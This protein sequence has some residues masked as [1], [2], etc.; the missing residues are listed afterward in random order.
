MSRITKA[1]LI[2]KT[3]LGRDLFEYGVHFID[4]D[5]V[6]VALGE[7]GQDV[8]LTSTDDLEEGS[9]HLYYTDARVQA[10]IDNA[11]LSSTD[12]LPE[13]ST[14]KYYTDARVDSRVETLLPDV[15]TSTDDLNE[16]AINKY[17]TDARVD[18]QLTERFNDEIEQDRGDGSVVKWSTSFAGTLLTTMANIAEHKI[19]TFLAGYLNE[20]GALRG[21]N[22]Y[23]TFSDSLVRAIIPSTGPAYGGASGNYIELQDRRVT[24]GAGR[25]LHGRR[26][27]DGA[28]MRKDQVITETYTWSYGDD[29][30]TDGGTISLPA[31]AAWILKFTADEATQPLPSW[32]PSGA[33]TVRPS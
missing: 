19:G 6:E 1:R 31:N 27:S 22:P 10:Q 18:D 28:L 13:G 12:D 29:D 8:V 7:A 17:Y 9:A 5:G 24:A 26:W 16:G 25:N 14:N 20:W 15:P 3:D 2:G 11:A 23:S 21:S 32:A 33:I 30:P 4:E